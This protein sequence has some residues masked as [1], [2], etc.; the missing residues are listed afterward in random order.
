LATHHRQKLTPYLWYDKEAKEA[1]AFYAEAFGNAPPKSTTPLDGTPSGSVEIVGTEIAGMSFTLISA[2]PYFKFTPA[3]SFLVAVKSKE[4]AANLWT[5]LSAGGLALMAFGAYPFSQAYGWTND[6]YGLS[7][8]V[9][10]Q[11]DHPIRQAVTPTLM[12]VGAQCGKA[13]EAIRFYASVFRDSA[14]G[15][16]L[17]YGAGGPDAEGTVQHAAF[18]LEGIDFAAMDSAYAHDFTF[19]EAVSFVI[20]CSD[21][22]E[23]DYYWGKLSADPKAERCGWLKDRYGVS[24][25]VVPSALDA[26]MSSGD[27]D[28]TAR[29][30]KAFLAMK[31]FDLAALERAYRG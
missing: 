14:V 1:A 30:T 2:G 25:Q 7:W 22:R 12:F 27:R 24:W 11:G 20:R 28:A 21:Q 8:Q 23:I 13:E 4:E 29:V 3:I 26:M 6:R 18:T 16:I 5:R 17:R 15:S 9:M 31:K 19:S 10:Y